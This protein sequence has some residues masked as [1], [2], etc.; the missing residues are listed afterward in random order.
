MRCNFSYR[1]LSL[2]DDSFDHTP[3]RCSD[4]LGVPELR[5]LSP[6]FSLMLCKSMGTVAPCYAK[7]DDTLPIGTSEDR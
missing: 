2:L 1:F 6:R 7:Q 5:N 4:L 3:N